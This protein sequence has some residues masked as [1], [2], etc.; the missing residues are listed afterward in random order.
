MDVKNCEITQVQH[1]PT[2]TWIKIITKLYKVSSSVR[3]SNKQTQ[4]TGFQQIL[5]TKVACPFV[6]GNI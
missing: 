3:V 6:F 2:I 4:L 5:I 1:K